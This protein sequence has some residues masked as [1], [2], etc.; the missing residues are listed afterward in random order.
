MPRSNWALD[1]QQ[2]TSLP[3]EDLLNGVPAHKVLTL[4]FIKALGH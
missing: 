3:T 1:R 2:L 4:P